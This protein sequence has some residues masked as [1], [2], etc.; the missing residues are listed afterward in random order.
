MVSNG[1][2]RDLTLT[3]PDG[4][5]ATVTVDLPTYRSA[6]EENDQ[7]VIDEIVKNY[8]E[9]QAQAE[10]DVI[11]S[12]KTV[13]QPELEVN[14]AHQPELEVNT[15]HQPEL[16]VNTSD[17]DSQS[18]ENISQS[19]FN[20][21]TSDTV[22]WRHEEVML[23]I[24]L[25]ADHQDMFSSSAYKAFQVWR[26][27][28]EEMA[29]K[30]YRFTGLQCDKKFRSLKYR[31]KTIVDANEKSGR[32]RRKW[33]FFEAMDELLAGDPSVRP[34][35]VL[36]STKVTSKP[37][38]PP[39]DSASETSALARASSTVQVTPRRPA[40]PQSI[41]TPT[42]PGRTPNRATTPP[43][44]APTPP[45]RSTTPDG[46]QQSRKRRR[47]SSSEAPA[48]FTSFAEEHQKNVQAMLETTKRLAAA[49]EQRN[50]TLARLVEELL[51]K[52]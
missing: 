13:H 5:T 6:V 9:I 46:E 38:L 50:A 49:A 3:F 31:Y 35:S 30:G 25:Y 51:K 24:S 10:G 21:H 52:K 26:R 28:A 16:D 8:N 15:A 48:W 23:L 41:E 20:I 34:V 40:T 47:S 39:K 44:R 29:T 43:I 36:S 22:N 18:K 45:G 37:P 12:K 2:L 1:Y 14:T 17:S 4:K 33:E 32:G 27:I 11:Q 42:P 19:E 7:S